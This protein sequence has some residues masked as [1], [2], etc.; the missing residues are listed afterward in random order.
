MS[1]GSA[2]NVRVEAV[3][4]VAD[5]GKY[6]IVIGGGACVGWYRR[7]VVL[8]RLDGAVQTPG[9]H[10]HTAHSAYAQS[11]GSN[12]GGTHCPDALNALESHLNFSVKAFRFFVDFFVCFSINILPLTSNT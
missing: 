11:A 4:S 10:S 6:S 5:R 8:R 1:S 3:Q 9:T 12:S 7:A 2:E